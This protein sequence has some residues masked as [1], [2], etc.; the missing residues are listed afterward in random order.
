MHRTGDLEVEGGG[1]G[2]AAD[3]RPALAA[4]VAGVVVVSAP[5]ALEIGVAL[6]FQAAQRTKL[7][8]S[9]A[10]PGP[11]PDPSNPYVFGPSGS[12]SGSF[13]HQAKV[14]RKTCIPTVLLLLFDFLSSKINMQKNLFKKN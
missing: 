9:V 12:G 5:R 3:E 11:N 7:V 10:A 2:V 8:N 4:G 13:Y 14:V 6:R 1:A